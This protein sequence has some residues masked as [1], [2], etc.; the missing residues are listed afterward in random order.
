V[1]DVAISIGSATLTRLAARSVGLLGVLI[2][3]RPRSISLQSLVFGIGFLCDIGYLMPALTMLLSLMT[4]T[5]VF[6][7]S[8]LCRIKKVREEKDFRMESLKE[9][10]RL[11]MVLL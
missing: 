4:V 11:G 9:K 8:I 2:C 1:A 3:V 10:S 7:S 6:G 5:S